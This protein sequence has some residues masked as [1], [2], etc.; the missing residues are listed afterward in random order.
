MIVRVRIRLFCLLEGNESGGVGRSQTSSSVRDRL[1]RDG[2]F[3]EVVTGHLRLDFN[4]GEGLAVVDTS[5]GTDH[6]RD[7]DHVSQV[8]LDGGGLLVR[9]G[10]LLGLSQLLEETQVLSLESSL[11]PSSCS[12][13]DELDELL[14][15]EIKKLVE[16]DTSVL[17]LP[18]GPLPLQLGGLVGVGEV[19][20][21]LRNE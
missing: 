18:E 1:V 20:V 9:S 11:E 17:V 13:V 14:V 4:G 16:F 19:S 5:D 7:D 15:G 10:I 3:T 12:G 6:F 8:G 21:S 2:E